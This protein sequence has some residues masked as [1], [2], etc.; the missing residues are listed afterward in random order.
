MLQWLMGTK[1][2][3]AGQVVGRGR[4]W[5]CSAP[6]RQRGGRGGRKKPE[7]EVKR[8]R[9]H[10][11]SGV[12]SLFVWVISCLSTTQTHKHTDT[13]WRSLSAMFTHWFFQQDSHWHWIDGANPA[14]RGAALPG[15]QVWDETLSPHLI[16][17]QIFIT[18]NLPWL[19][20]IKI[21][22]IDNLL[23][24]NRWRAPAG[25][26]GLIFRRR[27]AGDQ[28]GEGHSSGTSDTK[29][30]IC[31]A[32]APLLHFNGG[33]VRTRRRKRCSGRNSEVHTQNK[34]FFII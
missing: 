9:T 20:D 5:S 2:G 15:L 4:G 16:F 3:T 8:G 25:S 13:H 24:E 19:R 21:L 27:R 23:Q 31:A 10:F 34:G 1:W 30:V 33:L 17:R 14:R 18:I 11:R 7:E 28:V 12:W 6:G 32:A 29:R 26:S 22:H